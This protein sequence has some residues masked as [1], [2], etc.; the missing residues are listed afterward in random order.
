MG[1]LT[2]S[3]A[4]AGERNRSSSRGPFRI[5][6]APEDRL[7][8][9]PTFATK[10]NEWCVGGAV[11]IR[12]DV[13]RR[14]AFAPRILRLIGRGGEGGGSRRNGRGKSR[15]RRLVATL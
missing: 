9:N 10:P 7:C 11:V 6:N 13:L 2:A 4:R 12:D 1:A 3:T 15:R 8:R 14:D 5:E